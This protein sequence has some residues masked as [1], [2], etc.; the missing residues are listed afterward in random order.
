MHDTRTNR[1]VIIG[2]VVACAYAASCA[3]FGAEDAPEQRADP[4]P[5]IAVF[6]FQSI[7]DEGELGRWVAA[8]VRARLVLKRLYTMIEEMEVSEAAAANEFAVEYDS[9][10][11]EVAAFA[12]ENLGCDLAMW[13]RVDVGASDALEIKVKLA[14]TGDNPEFV[15][16]ETFIAENRH[17]TSAAVEEMLRRLANEEKPKEEY[18]PE[19]DN[20]WEKNPNLV[21]N[22]GFE[23]GADHPAHW[24]GLNTKD[25]HHDMVH[26]V[27]APG[28][29]GRGKCIKFLMNADIAATYGVGYYSDPIDTSKGTR[30]RFSVRVRSD[31]PT[32]KIFLKHYAY[33]PPRGE[34][35]E[36]QWRETRRAPLNCH[37][38]GRQWKT[39]IRDFQPRRDD[40]Y[41]PKRTKVELYAYWPEGTV[42]FDDAVLKRI[43]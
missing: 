7:G 29:R 42:Y 30:Y 27:T 8:N 31:A 39:F 3:A 1:I 28:P 9:P 17:V 25:Y 5:V 33:F 40:A 15:M 37:G 34:E 10:I 21:K 26:W 43:E 16:N 35:K 32:V 18:Q 6:D 2:A 24:E 36:G 38:A 4:K 11:T 19:W 23:E 12:R 22:P 41:D 14:T 20:A 13:G